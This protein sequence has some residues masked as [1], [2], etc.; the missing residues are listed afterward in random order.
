M[1]AF[2]VIHI[3]ILVLGLTI[4]AWNFL[5]VFP[6]L[7]ALDISIVLTEAALPRISKVVSL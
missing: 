3:F 5:M 6:V 7:P 2:T 1:F 4:F